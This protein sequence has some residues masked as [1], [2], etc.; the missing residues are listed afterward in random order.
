VKARPPAAVV[1]L[2]KLGLLTLLAS[3]LASCGGL[4][5]GM[6]V[7]EANRL[8]GDERLHEAVAL[9][10]KAGTAGFDGTVAYDLANAFGAMGE[11][12]SA[13]PLFRAAGASSDP[14][15][16]ASA[17]HNLGAALYARSDYEGAA[18]AFRRSLEVLPG[19]PETARAYELALEAMR[20]KTE[21]GAIERSRFSA[22]GTGGEQSLFSVS[23]PG[24]RPLYLPGA[25]GSGGGV[26]H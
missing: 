10:L 16:A 26:D 2:A 12:R 17:W 19:R 7:L 14:V 4:V 9:Y 25:A 20:P 23:R 24:Q 6:S 21:A 3:L 1:A 13:E 18:Q 8:F 5:R 11:H 15:V 22:G